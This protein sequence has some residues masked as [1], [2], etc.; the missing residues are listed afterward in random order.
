M[1]IQYIS[2]FIEVL[3]SIFGLLIALHK[4]KIYGWGIFLTFA[5]YVLYDIVRLVG[6]SISENVLYGLF[7]V[8]TVSALFAVYKIYMEKKK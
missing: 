8:A 1:I 4:R 2:I 7:F 3:I 5:I 6:F